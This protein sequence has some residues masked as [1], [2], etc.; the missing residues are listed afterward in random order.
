MEHLDGVSS[1]TLSGGK[2]FAIKV[3]GAK[4]VKPMDLVAAV[5]EKYTSEEL[6]IADFAGEVKSEKDKLVITG[7]SKLSFE[8]VKGTSDKKEEAE[9]LAKL[10]EDFAQTVK[11]GKKKFKVAGTLA[12]KKDAP[13][14]LTGFAVVKDE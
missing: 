3:D 5:P 2:V 4:S 10:F 7:G 1:A 11:G 14:G 13:V 8:I 9:R 6:S 12:L